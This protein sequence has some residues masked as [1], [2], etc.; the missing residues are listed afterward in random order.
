M[1]RGVVFAVSIILVRALIGATIAREKCRLADVHW[2]VCSW[3]GM[4]AVG[5]P[6]PEPPVP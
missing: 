4:P 3:M 5:G 1:T 6:F 2:K